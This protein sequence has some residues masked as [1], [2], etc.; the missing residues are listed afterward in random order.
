MHPSYGR[1]ILRVKGLRVEILGVLLL[2]GFA[3]HAAAQSAAAEVWPEVKTYIHLSTGTRLYLLT[4]FRDVDNQG[5]WSWSGDFGIH[6]D[7]ALRPIF[8]RELGAREDVFEKRYLSFLAGYRYLTNLSEGGSVEHRWLVETTAKFPLKS[9]LVLS[10]RSRGEMRFLS[11]GFSPRYRN[12]LQVESDLHPD[13]F[14]FTPYVSAEAFFDTRFNTWNRMRYQ[15][16]ARF[17][18]RGH[19][20]LDTYY[21]RQNDT[22]STPHHVNA[23][24][25]TFNLYF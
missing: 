5:A 9:R 3:S 8:R 16:G 21:L 13:G 24:G 22:R 4:G 20:V 1:S 23:L 7:F 10:D 14:R 12:R 25:L 6:F 11:T 18:A 19:F 15:F 17:P 2:A